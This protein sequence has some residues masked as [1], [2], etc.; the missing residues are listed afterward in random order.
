MPID[1]QDLDYQVRVLKEQVKVLESALNEARA[2]ADLPA[3]K[4]PRPR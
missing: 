4:I 3:I 2:K 1:M